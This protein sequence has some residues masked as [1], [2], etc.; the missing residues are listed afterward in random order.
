MASELKS[1][2]KKFDR[3]C[4]LLNYIFNSTV[5][6]NQQSDFYQNQYAREMCV[7]RLHDTWSRFCRELILSSAGSKPKTSN[8]IRLPRSPGV[9]KYGDVLSLVQSI[10]KRP[11]W[12]EPAWHNPAKCL[13][14]ATKLRI[15][16]YSTI[17][18]G[19][20]LS[21]GGPDPSEQLTVVRNYFAHRNFSTSQAIENLAQSLFISPTP[22]AFEL[23][24][25]LQSGVTLFSLWTIRLKTMAQLSIQ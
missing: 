20:S 17:L 4:S 6:T 24:A 18:Q 9:S 11:N 14:V 22:R 23:V 5:K 1:I 16:N 15:P 21:F 3:E 13:D 19:L 7:V 12:W 8:G 2:Y 10:Y 25:T